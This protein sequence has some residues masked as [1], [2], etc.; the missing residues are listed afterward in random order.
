MD[1][2]SETTTSNDKEENESVD[3]LRSEYDIAVK[4][5][6]G[7]KFKESIVVLDSIIFSD[8]N[9]KDLFELTI[10]EGLISDSEFFLRIFR[11]S[12]LIYSDTFD[13]YY[14]VKFIFEPDTIPRNATQ[15]EF[16]DYIYSYG[17]A[18]KKSDFEK[19][20]IE[21][22]RTFFNDVIL[23]TYQLR[24]AKEFGTVNDSI[25]FESVITD[26]NSRVITFP[27]FDCDYGSWY[28]AYSKKDKK[29]KRILETD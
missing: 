27:C 7:A 6:R 8:P 23:T 21:S 24:E 15:Q 14:F 12:N 19:H 20:A 13:T 5:L 11:D 1:E 17:S 26:T 25:L 9:R 4:T 16:E 28:F 10:N 18:L 29:V 22:A 3:S 2:S